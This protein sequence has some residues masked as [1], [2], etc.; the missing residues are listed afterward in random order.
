[1]WCGQLQCICKQTQ[2][3]AYPLV[4]DAAVMP[5][6]SLPLFPLVECTAGLYPQLHQT[7]LQLV[8]TLAISITISQ[9][10]GY[11]ASFVPS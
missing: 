1:M 2:G 7:G 9:Y 6:S 4:V 8:A 11:L 3:R 5:L 10:S